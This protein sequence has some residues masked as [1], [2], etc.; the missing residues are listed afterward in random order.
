MAYTNFDRHA[1][2]DSETRRAIL[3]LIHDVDLLKYTLRNSDSK[4]HDEDCTVLN[5]LSNTLYGLF[6][7]YLYDDLLIELSVY[8]K[9][10]GDDSA[11]KV[12]SI[13]NEV[14]NYP[15]C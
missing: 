11:K 14:S 5:N 4:V 7:G 12:T 1:N 3:D 13:F 6:D 10:K 15:K 9:H 2:M 8:V